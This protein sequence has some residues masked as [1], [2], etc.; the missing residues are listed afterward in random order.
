MGTLII[1][2]V[3]EA[4]IN[5]LGRMAER[6]GVPLDVQAKKVLN[7]GVRMRDRSDLVARLEAVAAMTPRGIEQTDSVEMLREDRDR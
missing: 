7:D 5:D 4:L 6:N 3:D 1:E 2:N